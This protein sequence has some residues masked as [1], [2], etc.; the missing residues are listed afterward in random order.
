MCLLGIVTAWDTSPNAIK[1]LP[2][3]CY[4]ISKGNAALL[5]AS[6]VLHKSNFLNSQF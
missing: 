5:I 2:I 3:L 4:H 1:P 6:F